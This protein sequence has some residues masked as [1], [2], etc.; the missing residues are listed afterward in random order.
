MVIPEPVEIGLEGVLGLGGL[1]ALE[2][3]VGGF[4]V[5][6]TWWA[7]DD[8]GPAC[9]VGDLLSFELGWWFL[10]AGHDVW[11]FFFLLFSFFIEW[12]GKRSDK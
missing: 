5:N 9:R 8:V 11:I 3:S 1:A 6:D 7:F 2:M 10:A 12:F 4:G